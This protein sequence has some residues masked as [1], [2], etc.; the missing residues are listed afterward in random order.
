MIEHVLTVVG[1]P[2]K[3]YVRRVSDSAEQS[4]HTLATRFSSSSS[5][6]A[7][8]SSISRSSSSSGFGFMLLRPRLESQ[9]GDQQ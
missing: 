9:H 5:V 8:F 7:G 2:M 4:K 6:N 1:L 3:D